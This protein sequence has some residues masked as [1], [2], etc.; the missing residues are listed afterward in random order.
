MTVTAERAMSAMLTPERA[1]SALAKDIPHADSTERVCGWPLLHSLL[2][3]IRDLVLAPDF[4]NTP[5]NSGSPCI[6]LVLNLM[7]HCV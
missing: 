5:R 1:A 7:P 6:E 2:Y 4:E 3:A